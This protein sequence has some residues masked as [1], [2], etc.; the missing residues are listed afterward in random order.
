MFDTENPTKTMKILPPLGWQR[1]SALDGAFPRGAASYGSTGG[2]STHT[3][4]VTI[5]TGGPSATGGSKAAQ[6][7]WAWQFAPRSYANCRQGEVG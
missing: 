5:T 7:G 2:S 3:H 4:S 6:R 1:F